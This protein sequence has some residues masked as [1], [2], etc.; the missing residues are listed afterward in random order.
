[1]SL[2]ESRAWCQSLA[3][4]TAGNFYY[5]FLTLP[6]E[7]RIDM[8]VLY[9]FMRISDDIG[10]DTTLPLETRRARLVQWH[11]DLRLAFDGR[12]FHHPLYPALMEMVARRNVPSRHLYEVI[13]GIE[14]DLAPQRFA[15]FDDLNRY[16]YHVAGAV[17][18]C[19]IHIWGFHDP[20]AIP[21]A[22]DCGTAFQ[23]TNILRDLKEDAAMGRVY[24]PQEDLARFGYRES[25]LA[26]SIYD[27]RFRSLMQFEVARAR[28]FYGRAAGLLSMVDAPGR[29]VLSAMLR[30]YAGVLNEI[31]RR[32]YDV[33][34]RRVRLPRWKKLW[35]AFTSVMR[36][37]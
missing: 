12:R 13:E 22:I 15:T 33:F 34:T 21:L 3:K 36:R 25:D 4:R 28:E 27:D 14:S 10:D 18:L 1:M 24:L 31:E 32:G 26:A 7:Q 6:K 19:C 9:A 30:I 23:L 2:A 8:C 16:C 11:E 5:S 17:G 35:I 37:R 29:P 20:Q